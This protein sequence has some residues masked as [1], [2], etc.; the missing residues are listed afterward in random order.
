M[1]IGFLAENP[2]SRIHLILTHVSTQINSVS[3]RSVEFISWLRTLPR[4]FALFICNTANALSN[5][6][7]LNPGLAHLLALS[8]TISS[9]IFP[10]LI[11]VWIII[12]FVGERWGGACGP[13]KLIAGPGLLYVIRSLRRMRMIRTSSVNEELLIWQC[14]D[15]GILNLNSYHYC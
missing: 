7:Q 6:P 10:L 11:F 5:L 13:P 2:C 12:G 3:L 4:H 9:E 14:D 8:P 15:D 1:T